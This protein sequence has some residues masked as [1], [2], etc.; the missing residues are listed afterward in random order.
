M[1]LE[2]N[3]SKLDA[4]IKSTHDEIMS[5]IS[6]NL[7]DGNPITDIYIEKDIAFKV[8]RK[9]DETIE[10]SGKSDNFRW[11]TLRQERNTLG[12][13]RMMYFISETIG[14]QKHYKLKCIS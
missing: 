2:L 6:R 3:T 11:M 1:N 10:E 4:R 12:H 13:G 5:E 14:D 8:K 7:A 9:I